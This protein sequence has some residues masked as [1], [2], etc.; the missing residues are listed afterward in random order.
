VL[1]RSDRV[2]FGRFNRD[3]RVTQHCCW[4]GLSGLGVTQ[5]GIWVTCVYGSCEGS[6]GISLLSLVCSVWVVV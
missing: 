4:S 2:A 3:Y 1:N 5:S 6:M